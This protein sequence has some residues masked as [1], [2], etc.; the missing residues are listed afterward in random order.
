[1]QWQQQRTVPLL[2]LLRLS[3]P[4]PFLADGMPIAANWWSYKAAAAAAA[5]ADINNPTCN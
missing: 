3:L 5:A 4:F 1:M 2:I